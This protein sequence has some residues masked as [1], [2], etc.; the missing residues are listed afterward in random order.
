MQ[1]D[2]GNI[3]WIFYELKRGEVD[4]EHLA[5]ESRATF[6]N[7]LLSQYLTAAT[8][9]LQSLRARIAAIKEYNDNRAQGAPYV[10]DSN[11]L[12]MIDLLTAQMK[13]V[14]ELA[15]E[16]EVVPHDYRFFWVSGY[17]T[18]M[19]TKIK[20]A[21]FCE[22]HK[23]NDEAGI[24]GALALSDPNEYFKEIMTYDETH[25]LMEGSKLAALFKYA[26]KSGRLNSYNGEFMDWLIAEGGFDVDSKIDFKVALCT[27]LNHY[28][29]TVTGGR[30]SPDGTNTELCYDVF[31]PNKV[32]LS[33]PEFY[34]KYYTNLVYGSKYDYY[35][36][37]EKFV[38][39]P[40]GSDNHNFMLIGAV[41]E[42]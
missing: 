11:V 14:G 12:E 7:D 15:S 6:H 41:N 2:S 1:N 25:Q 18:K 9:D 16:W 27:P 30:F 8:I 20:S 22:I 21:N 3:F 38:Y 32:A 31:A 42:D 40:K 28:E 36:L 17:E 35:G 33:Y 23:A 4:W 24:D 26:G 39:D 19:M 37:I 13:A 29:G 34:D 10:S 5:D